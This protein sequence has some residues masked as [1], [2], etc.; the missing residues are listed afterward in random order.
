MKL[1]SQK[2]LTFWSDSAI[3]SNI[4]SIWSNFLCFGEFGLTFFCLDYSLDG[5]IYWI[6]WND[7][8]FLKMKLSIKILWLI[9]NIH[10]ICY[11]IHNY[12]QVLHNS[13][14]IFTFNTHKYQ[15]I[16]LQILQQ[17]IQHKIFI[18]FILQQVILHF[19][20]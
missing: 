2:L 16:I 3:W 7:T 20:F 14:V 19:D 12:P 9:S 8:F 11:K 13:F 10:K 15:L 18:I 5:D 6:Y 1:I 4:S 17:D